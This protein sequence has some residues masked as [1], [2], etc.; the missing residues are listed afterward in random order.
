MATG[1][2]N[3]GLH[4]ERTLAAQIS[5]L[6]SEL[7]ALRREAGKRGAESYEDARETTAE[8]IDALR[9][10]IAASSHDMA[11]RARHAGGVIRDNP[12]TAVTAA[13]VGVV[14]AGLMA[15]LVSTLTHR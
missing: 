8:L 12:G 13:A 10:G 9:D 4:N 14:V 2:W 15:S 6:Q 3:N 11:K 1:F 5:A 7:R